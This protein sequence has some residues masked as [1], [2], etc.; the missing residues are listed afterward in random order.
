MFGLVP[1]RLVIYLKMFVRPFPGK[2]YWLL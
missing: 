2:P 1:V